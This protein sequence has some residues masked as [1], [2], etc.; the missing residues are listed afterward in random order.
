LFAAVY[1]F[2][3]SAWGAKAPPMIAEGFELSYDHEMIMK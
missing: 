3:S 2:A 1:S